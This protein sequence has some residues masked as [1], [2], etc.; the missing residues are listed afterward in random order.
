M[1][2]DEML[3]TLSIA[4]RPEPYTLVTVDEPVELGGGVAAL[5]AEDEGTTVV[6]ACTE[7]ER[8]GWPVGFVAVWLTVEVHSALEAVGL[9]AAMSAALAERGIPCNVLAGHFHDHL[10]VPAERAQDAVDA[11]ESLREARSRS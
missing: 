9:T 1:D 4:R 3:A 2:L 11:L 8:R 5:L 7:A 10:L 6:V